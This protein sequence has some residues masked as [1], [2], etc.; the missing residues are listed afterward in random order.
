MSAETGR[1]TG[2]LFDLSLEC[3]H[4]A[5]QMCTS[6]CESTA[7]ADIMYVGVYIYAYIYIY[8]YYEQNKEN[9]DVR[10]QDSNGQL[11]EGA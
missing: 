10:S 7:T 2:D 6:D 11:L 1:Q 5:T 8:I 4:W 9:Q 3:R